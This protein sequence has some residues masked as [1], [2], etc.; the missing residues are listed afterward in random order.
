MT[1]RIT[2]VV[3][4]PASDDAAWVTGQCFT[5]DGGLTAAS[6]LRPGFF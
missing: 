2:L 3:A 6:P 1:A 4:W 5:V